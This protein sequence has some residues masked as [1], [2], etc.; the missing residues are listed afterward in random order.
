MRPEIIVELE[1]ERQEL[2]RK[3]ALVTDLLDAY[4]PI[5]NSGTVRRRIR[6]S[7]RA[8]AQQTSDPVLDGAAELIDG[9]S[10]PTRT[11]VIFASLTEQGISIEGKNPQ[12]TLSARLSNSPRFISHGRA[13][14][15][16]A[17]PES[18]TADE[19]PSSAVSDRDGLAK[20][21]NL[22]GPNGGG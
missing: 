8:A 11:A 6:P 10:D 13:G 7:L 15:T 20:P 17:E 3:L 9:R 14:W 4:G 1:R 2:E 21:V 18:E 16:L 5:P 22:F 19:E 12:N